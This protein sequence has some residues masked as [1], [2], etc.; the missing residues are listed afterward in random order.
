M[1][2]KMKVGNMGDSAHH[3]F[4]CGDCGASGAYTCNAPPRIR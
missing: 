1:A 3:S 2:A 4:S